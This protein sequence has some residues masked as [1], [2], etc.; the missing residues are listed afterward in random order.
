MKKILSIITAISIIFCLAACSGVDETGQ[1]YLENAVKSMNFSGVFRIT[2]DGKPFCEVAKN[3]V[4]TENSPKITADTLFCVG[5]V[6]KQFTAC[7][8]MML[9]EEGKLSLDD[10]LEKFF[11]QYAAGKQLTVKNLLTM[12][13]GI[14]EFYDVTYIDNA[15]TELPPAEL[16]STVTNRKTAAENQKALEAWLFKQP[17]TF[18]ADSAYTYSNSNY[19]LLARIVEIVSG[20]SFNGFIRKRIFE[21]LGMKNSYFIDDVNLKT[22]EG[23][24]QPTVNP[25]T[26]YVGVTMG[27]GDIISN[28]GDIE[29][30]LNSLIE[31]R[32]ISQKSVRAMTTDYSPEAESTYGFGL[33]PDE[34]GGAYHY[35]YITT[36]QAMVYFNADKKITAF[37]VTNDDAHIDGNLPQLFHTMIYRACR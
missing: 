8:I 14:T 17:L 2:C 28:A 26:V 1:A 27:L 19:F 37:A 36:F 20:E 9:Y 22:L 11:P 23:L 16:R 13:S 5:S 29:L 4:Q 10:R 24:A 35:G 15:F 30:W 32:L 34:T 31:H 7:A 12:R 6:S 25:Q 21:P 33:I 18:K 3:N